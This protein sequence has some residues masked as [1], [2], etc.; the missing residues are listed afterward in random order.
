LAWGLIAVGPS[1]DLLML[2]KEYTSQ[3]MRG[4]QS[5]LTIGKTEKKKPTGVLI[6]IM[7][8][9]GAKVLAKLLLCLYP[10]SMV[11]VVK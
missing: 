10:T 9:H 11:V 3:T 4:G 6:K 7:P 8:L 1:V 5:E 2:T